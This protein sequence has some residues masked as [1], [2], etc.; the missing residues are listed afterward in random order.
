MSGSFKAG[1]EKFND[2]AIYGSCQCHIQKIKS[3]FFS[4]LFSPFQKL[5]IFTVKHISVSDTIKEFFY[6]QIISV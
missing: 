3:I 5:S 2:Y 4:L 6:M 1:A